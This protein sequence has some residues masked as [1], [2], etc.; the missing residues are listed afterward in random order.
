MCCLPFWGCF[1]S[2]F[3][4]DWRRD[5]VRFRLVCSLLCLEDFLGKCGCVIGVISA[6]LV[7]GRLCLGALRRQVRW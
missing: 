2:M 5:S 1:L 6:G 3:R 7:V 4:W